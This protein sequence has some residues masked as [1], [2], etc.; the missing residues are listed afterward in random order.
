MMS[1][2]LILLLWTQ[3]QLSGE[4]LRSR[5]RSSCPLATTFQNWR[6][7]VVL[8]AGGVASWSRCWLV[9]LLAGGWC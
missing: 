3:L 6:H 4:C 1:L 7:L 9:V 2:L 5:S 8:L